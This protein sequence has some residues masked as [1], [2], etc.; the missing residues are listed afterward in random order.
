PKTQ[1][2]ID[3]KITEVTNLEKILTPRVPD[4]D[5]ND[6]AGKDQQVNVGET[7]KAEDSIGNLP[8]LPKGT[9]VAFE[10]PV[11][12]ATPGGKPAKVVVTYP[13]GSKDTVDVT[14]KVV[15]PRT[16]ADKNDPAGKNQQVNGKGNKLPATGEKVTPFV[17]FA[18]LAIISSVG[19]LGIAKGKKNGSDYFR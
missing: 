4:A 16:D 5:K 13:D 19:L 18:A 15:D 7:P 12:T 11:D 1:S 14:V 3:N 10:T 8:D 17:N 9:T 6:P 2:D